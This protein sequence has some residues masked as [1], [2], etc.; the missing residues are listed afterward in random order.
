MITRLLE[1]ALTASSKKYPIIG[2]TGPRQS[3][4]TSLA[5]FTF[6]DYHYISL[7]DI[8]NRTFAQ[9][10]PRG[11]LATY[12]NH[13]IFDEIQK[14][15][16]LFSYLQTAVDENNTPGRYIITGSQNF[17]LHRSISQSLAGRIALFTLLPLTLKELQN[18]SFGFKTWEEYV[19]NGMY[20][21]I[22]DQK[23]SPTSWY[24]NY[25]TT[26]VERDVRDLQNISDLSTFQTFI[27]LCAG[28]IGQVIN[29]S[30]LGRDCGISHNTAKAWIS[31]L[32]ASYII[33]TLKPYFEN[34][35]KRL[36]KSHKLYFY[37]T[38]LACSLLGIRNSNEISTHYLKGGLFENFVITEYIKYI[39][40]S[41][42]P[43]QLS[44]FRDKQGHEI[45][46]LSESS[47]KLSA[48]EAKSGKT[49]SQDYIK[50]LLY[51]QKIYSKKGK[52]LSMSVIYGGET[53]QIRK[54]V[55]IE[56]WEKI[57][58]L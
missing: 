17:Q 14:V 50:N 3:G 30:S 1:K 11:F 6:K 43:I 7:E 37:D 51:F 5:K 25:I 22:Y 48:I 32:E 31:L 12:N 9:D 47:T 20:P 54:G 46:L 55:T 38:G 33:Y 19:F 23:I 42:D 8:D 53:K 27:R 15:P 28:R 39:A 18:A 36:V 57:P 45:D 49:T 35:G 4:K 16:T 40:N 26:Y 13:V 29:L 2:I 52:P 58:L 24:P 10:D 34:F 44:F 21:R 41:Q 56:C